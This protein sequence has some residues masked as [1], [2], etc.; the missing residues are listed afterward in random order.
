MMLGV[1]MLTFLLH[2]AVTPHILSLPLDVFTVKLSDWRFLSQQLAHLLD[3]Q[4]RSGIGD[5]SSV[6]EEFS[7]QG[8]NLEAAHE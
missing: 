1:T 5:R 2:Y 6:V 3:G 8:F 4:I 7:L